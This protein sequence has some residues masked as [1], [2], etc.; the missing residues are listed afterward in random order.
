MTTFLGSFMVRTPLLVRS[1]DVVWRICPL[2][3]AQEPLQPPPYYAPPPDV[4]QGAGG[5]AASVQGPAAARQ[6]Q[7]MGPPPPRQLGAG[8]FTPMGP[9]PPRAP[10][11][12][13][14]VRGHLNPVQ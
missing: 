1:A 3:C 2:Q 7:V 13:A 12:S 8:G 4:Q 14:G 5:G 9:P 10:A 11:G 6:Q